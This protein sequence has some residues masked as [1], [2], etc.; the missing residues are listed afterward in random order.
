MGDAKRRKQLDPDFGVVSSSEAH[1]SSFIVMSEPDPVIVKTT[2]RLTTGQSCSVSLGRIFELSQS[3]NVSAL[4]RRNAQPGLVVDRY[5]SPVEISFE[6]VFLQGFAFFA[7]PYSNV[8]IGH[9]WIEVRG[10]SPS[11]VNKIAKDC[12]RAIAAMLQARIKGGAK[13]SFR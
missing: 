7:P 12:G 8:R 4:V 13:F 3:P 6:E 11:Q 1:H 2:V 9:L 10:I 5:Y